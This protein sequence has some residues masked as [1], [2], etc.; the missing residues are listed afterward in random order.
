MPELRGRL[1]NNQCGRLPSVRHH[2]FSPWTDFFV[3]ASCLM[4]LGCRESFLIARLILGSGR[5]GD[6]MTTGKKRLQAVLAIRP[7]ETLASTGDK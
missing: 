4:V 1:S 7:R 2:F 5:S 6:K 3:C